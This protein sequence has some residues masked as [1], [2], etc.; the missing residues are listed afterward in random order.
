MLPSTKEGRVWMKISRDTLIIG[1]VVEIRT[2][3]TEFPR[4]FLLLRDGPE[5]P[6]HLSPHL[7]RCAICLARGR[8]GRWQTRRVRRLTHGVGISEPRFRRRGKMESFR[9]PGSLFVCRAKF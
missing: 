9:N 5:H 1:S 3:C 6:R 2:A 4:E 7:Y 8:R